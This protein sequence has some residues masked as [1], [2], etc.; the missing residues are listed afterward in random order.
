LF[1]AQ[2]LTVNV[3]TNLFNAYFDTALPSEPP[4]YFKSPDDRS[5]NLHEIPD[6]FPSA[7]PGS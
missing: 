1:G 2:P 3:F 4:R 5:L 7:V 6:P